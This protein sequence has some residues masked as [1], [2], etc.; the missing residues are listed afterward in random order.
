[1]LRLM[2]QMTEKHGKLLLVVLAAFLM[3]VFLIPDQFSAP[4][5]P[6]LGTL[7]GDTI[8]E[9][10]VQAM[11]TRWR[12]MGLR[13]IGRDHED[14]VRNMYDSYL[15][16]LAARRHGVRVGPKMIEEALR[17]E[18]A[19]TQRIEYVLADPE[20]LAGQIEPS[21]AELR[22][23]YDKHR[24][25][26]TDSFEDARASVLQEVR[27]ERG[28]EM[29]RR[30]IQEAQARIAAAPL[31]G[32]EQRR[33]FRAAAETTGLTYEQTER[34]FTEK[35]AA[36][37]LPDL[38]LSFVST[39]S[40]QPG[41]HGLPPEF[42]K[43]LFNIPVGQPSE[44]MRSGDKLFVFRVVEATAGFN[45]EGKLALRDLGWSID[46]FAVIRQYANYEAL[47][48]DKIR[49]EPSEA[50]LAVN[51]H[52]TVQKYLRLVCGGSA[53]ATLVTEDMLEQLLAYENEE[54]SAVAARIPIAPFQKAETPDEAQLI[55]YY[56]SRRRVPQHPDVPN[57]GYLR[58][59][60]IQ[61]EYVL[62]P[63]K[64]FE[65][66][67]RSSISDEQIRAYYERHKDTKFARADDQGVKAFAEVRSEI[68]RDLRQAAASTAARE[69]L[70]DLMRRAQTSAGAVRPLK[71]L[72]DKLG[73]EYRVSPFF[74]QHEIKSMVP[75]L[76]D[77]ETF[78]EQAFSKGLRPYTTPLPEGGEIKI[79]PFSPVLE[80]QGAQ[81]IFRLRAYRDRQAPEYSE[82]D[83]AARQQVVRD[84]RQV[85]AVQR[86]LEAARSIRAEIMSETLAA[87]AAENGLEVHR[88][89]IKAAPDA[90]APSP[91]PPTLREHVVREMKAVPGETAVLFKDADACYSV[92]VTAI[93]KAI[94]ETHIAYLRFDPKAML[95][96]V[97]PDPSEVAERA[98]DIREKLNAES[99]GDSETP[100]TKPSEPT[101]ED[102][103]QARAAL[104]AERRALPI[105]ARYPDYFQQRLVQAFRSHIASTPLEF[106][107]E[108]RLDVASPD[109]F[110]IDDTAPLGGDAALIR[111]AFGLQRGEL[112]GPV[113]GDHSA[114]VMWLE[115]DTT[116]DEVKVEMISV[117][118]SQYDPLNVKVSDK[119]ARA[120]YEAHTAEFATPPRARAEYLFASFRKVA[121]AFEAEISEE[122]IATYYEAN[123]AEAYA[124]R[125][126][127]DTLK[128]T[129]RS[130]LAL[131]RAKA[132]A[133]KTAIVAA[134]KAVPEASFEQVA[135]D[136]PLHAGVTPMLRPSDNAIDFI[137]YAPTLVQKILA[138]KPGELSE[139][140]EVDDGWVLFRVTERV[141]ST[142]PPVEV[143]LPAARDRVRK[144][145]LEAQAKAGLEAIRAAL[146]KDAQAGIADLV[147]RPALM[148]ALP[149]GPRVETTQFFDQDRALNIPQMTSALRTEVFATKAGETTPVIVGE[150]LVQFARVI[151]A[152]KNRLVRVHAVLVGADLFSG[153]EQVSEADAQA[154]YAAHQ[155]RYRQPVRYETEY[156]IASAWALENEMKPSEEEIE[157]AYQQLKQSFA[158]T[159][160]AETTYKPL[161]EVRSQVL[162]ALRTHQANA[163]AEELARK[164]RELLTQGKTLKEVADELTGLQYVDQET[165]QPG[166]ENAPWDFRRV[167]GLD[168]FLESAKA[169]DFSPVLRSYS[170][171]LIVRLKQVHPAGVPEFQKIAEEVKDDVATQRGL[172]EARKMIETVVSR[173][174]NPESPS[175]EALR[176][177][178]EQFTVTQRVKERLR[179]MDIPYH[180]RSEP[181]NF[182][183][184][185]TPRLFTLLPG[186]VSEPPILDGEKSQ[187]CY[188]AALVGRRQGESP[189]A[190]WMVRQFGM[191]AARQRVAKLIDS[192]WADFRATP[193]QQ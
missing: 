144:Q 108:V 48:R 103:A 130:L 63:Q 180:K 192:I 18:P 102:L 155:D 30:K 85:Q 70:A 26:Q 65:E 64:R 179:P 113:T 38:A 43:A 3:V 118:P 121:A 124:N 58:M 11:N 105:E 22:A 153:K 165:Y 187:E 190:E 56:N 100:E 69:V 185:I 29:A 84:Y 9:A 122:A 23:W 176:Q 78:A 92:V 163:R 188:L 101:A 131:N 95:S 157:A 89:V 139:P 135:Q 68:V 96:S 175:V 8:H 66:Q 49:L 34:P 184:A 106:D 145:R 170:G 116:R 50:A 72:A 125:P 86:A 115:A 16:L 156:V 129:I 151:E 61:I 28:R 117:R 55:A 150:D 186:Q 87:I 41:D 128:G 178:A 59:E 111:A 13:P 14:T 123:R 93:G 33:A 17:H 83:E 141:E 154:H 82:L 53:Q 81:F 57:F 91:V 71:P 169:G 193:A 146:A 51:E 12:R 191:V 109:F 15:L 173:I 37:A 79:H 171:R 19:Q 140:V 32:H 99:S 39:S 45:A 40:N 21:D 35:Y 97:E 104:V 120:Y 183:R 172:A 167:A 27:Q 77:A 143:A 54:V 1:M 67:A 162:A 6:S 60:T 189:Y 75:E 25:D 36:Q 110:H 159:D 107:Q 31:Q 90:E 62:A 47:F 42:K 136:S 88:A 132:E 74:A 80:S 76:A 94:D 134:A 174:A 160:G 5:E 182:S 177:A 142:T 161:S 147:K 4:P 52:M 152:K 148:A 20:A 98:Q 181:Q 137:G 126:L 2:N 149:F 168:A 10:S 133:A 73:L 7:Y 164:A 44:V 127:D 119:D 158:K 46:R 166:D 112:S 114:A 24:A 138:A